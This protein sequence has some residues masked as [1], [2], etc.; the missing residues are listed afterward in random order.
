MVKWQ[1]H[2][3]KWLMLEG[4]KLATF[5]KEVL[6]NNLHTIAFKNEVDRMEDIV[7][8]FQKNLNHSLEKFSSENTLN[9]KYFEDFGGIYMMM[10]G[11]LMQQ[12]VDRE[13]IRGMQ[14]KGI[15]YAN[16]NFKG[17]RKSEEEKLLE[18]CRF[19]TW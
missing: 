1:V 17:G 2:I 13:D 3:S 14:A 16:A 8:S 7:D 6:T 18:V 12:K 19:Y 5:L 11:L 4:V 9:D 15:S 10:L